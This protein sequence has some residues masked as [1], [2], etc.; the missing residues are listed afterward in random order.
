MGS[1]LL[2]RDPGCL[3]DY[4]ALAERMSG[5]PVRR[6]CRDGPLTDLT[7]TDVA[8]PALF[9][10]CLALT[11]KAR[12][13]GLEPAMVSGHSLGEYTAAVV[14]GALT[15]EDG[16]HLVCQ[17]GM[18]MARVQAETQGTMAAVIGLEQSHLEGLVE[19]ARGDGVLVIANFNTPTQMVVSGGVAAV[20]RLWEAAVEE[21]AMLIRLEVAGA[22]HSPL[23]LPVED[24]MR[25]LARNIEWHDAAIP[26]V[27]NATAQPVQ[28]AEEVREALIAQ[29]AGPVRWSA[30]SLRMGQLGADSFLELGPGRAVSAMTRQTLAGADSVS[31]DSPDALMAFCEQHPQL[32][33]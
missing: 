32:V 31:A 5:H 1:A 22:F 6:L 19:A 10:V 30:S 23:M 28:A 21:G 9:A 13:M 20:D 14:A 12:S 17:R 18:L 26:I 4:L 27:A 16:M 2:E 25:E 24:Q 3:E 29:I 8:Q 7:R 33:A 11:D 15:V